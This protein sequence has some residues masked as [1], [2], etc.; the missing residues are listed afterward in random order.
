VVD[1]LA[2]GDGQLSW[3]L[4]TNRRSASLAMRL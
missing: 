4:T 2:G 1:G 3:Q